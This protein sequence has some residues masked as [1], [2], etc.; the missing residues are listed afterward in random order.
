MVQNFVGSPSFHS[1]RYQRILWNTSLLDKSQF[2]F[3]YPDLKLHNL[4]WDKSV[5]FTLVTEQKSIHFWN[6]VFSLYENKVLQLMSAGASWESFGE[7]YL[8]FIKWR[9]CEHFFSKRMDFIN[10]TSSTRLRTPRISGLKS[11]ILKPQFLS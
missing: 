6:S 3:V 9:L 1:K 8:V 7:R 2:D 5:W 10:L 4:Y 11:Q